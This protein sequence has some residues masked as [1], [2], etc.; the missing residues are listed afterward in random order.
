MFYAKGK[1]RQRHDIAN[2]RLIQKDKQHS[3]N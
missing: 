3:K 1:Q 2:I